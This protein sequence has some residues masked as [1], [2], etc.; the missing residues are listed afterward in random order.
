MHAQGQLINTLPNN[1]RT[2]ICISEKKLAESTS[3]QIICQVV[4]TK[5]EYFIHF[6]F[7]YDCHIG[8]NEI[9]SVNKLYKGKV[10]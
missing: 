5:R 10:E 4:R 2:Q 6:Y 3:C 9:N 8:K 1:I 7:K